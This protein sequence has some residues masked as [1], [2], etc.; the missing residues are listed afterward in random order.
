MI[1]PRCSDLP[2]NV[3]ILVHWGENRHTMDKSGGLSV[4]IPKNY[5]GSRTYRAKRDRERERERERETILMMRECHFSLLV[6]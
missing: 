1:Y 5:F 6:K 2:P 4:I 3:P